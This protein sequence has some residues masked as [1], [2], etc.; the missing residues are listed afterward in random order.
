MAHSENPQNRNRRGGRG[1][2]SRQNQ[3]H[4]RQRGERDDDRD[5]SAHNHH[6]REARAPRDDHR[7][8]EPVDRGRDIRRREAAKPPT[9]LQRVLSV[10]TFG[11]FGKKKTPVVKPPAR[12]AAPAGTKPVKRTAA[13]APREEPI[14]RTYRPPPLK[15]SPNPAPAAPRERKEPRA[16]RPAATAAAPDPS[17]ITVP[18]LHVG[19]LSYDAAESDLRELFA[20]FGT[21]RGVEVV[22]HRRTQRSKGFAFVEM[23]S[24]ED[25]RRAVAELH[26][27][28]YMGR[29]MEL[30]PAR[31]PEPR[32][33]ED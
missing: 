7:D 3:H 19:N 26:G 6:R 10:L 24:V 29:R 16:L 2:N 28:D 1:R 17:T 15:E 5:S 21:V 12:A 32:R 20:G 11:Y 30:G 25:A 22:Y 13:S 33:A 8:W 4:H 27:K 9:L 23:M 18:R 14:N 31:A